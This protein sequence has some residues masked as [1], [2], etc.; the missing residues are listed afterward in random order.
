LYA[1]ASIPPNCGHGGTQVNSEKPTMPKSP[2]TKRLIAACLILLSFTFV[3]CGRNN[4]P[5]DEA[6]QPTELQWMTFDE[7]SQVEQ[8]MVENYRAEHP[9]ITFNRQPLNFNQD[10]LTTTP[11]P[12]LLMFFNNR[13]YAEASRANL[14]ADL[15]EVWSNAALDEAMLPTV[16]ALVKDAES[17]KPHMMPIAFAWAGVYYNQEIFAQ[18]GLQTPQTWDEFMQ[19]CAILQANGE[20]PLAMVG[21]ESYAFPL[22]FDYLNL[23]LNGAEF[24]R[25]LLA[26]QERWDDPRVSL[27]LEMWRTLFDQGFVVARP[28]VMGADD[29][30]N[31]LMRQDNGVLPGEEAVMVLMD[32][33]TISATPLEFRDE[34]AFFRFPIIDP[35]IPLAETVDVIGYVIPAHATYPLQAQQFL[36]YLASPASSALIAR[37]AAVINAVYAPVRADLDADALT[38]DMQQAHAMLQASAESLPFTAQT[39][40]APLWIAFNRAYRQLLSDKQ[41]IQSFMDTMD[42]A[43]QSAREAGEIAD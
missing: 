39:M 6:A 5:I 21:T 33:Y 43:R 7:A 37:E 24:H 15:S 1:D 31:A 9:H 20:S 17:G 14:L 19:I 11:A 22:W 18:Y 35:A 29:A 36:T 4:A 25:A 30:I 10:Y 27:T 32:T 3:A 38:A 12:D 34:F 16:Q 23:R 2:I 28:E 41:D 42:S 13:A 8:V 40:P 26:G